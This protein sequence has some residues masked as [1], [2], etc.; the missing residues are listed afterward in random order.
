MT[1][2]TI[3]RKC[4]EIKQLFMGTELL[5]FW[6]NTI[7]YFKIKHMRIIPMIIEIKKERT[8]NPGN[9]IKLSNQLLRSLSDTSLRMFCRKKASPWQN[10]Q[11][12]KQTKTSYC[13]VFHARS[14]SSHF[15]TWKQ[16]L[17]L[18]EINNVLIPANGKTTVY[19]LGLHPNKKPGDE[20]SP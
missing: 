7:I 20:K 17:I 18:A 4:K 16:S 15:Y 12:N 1:A 8:M 13:K 9:P 10:K 19:S 14:N 6:T 3:Q 11:T 2:R 5:E